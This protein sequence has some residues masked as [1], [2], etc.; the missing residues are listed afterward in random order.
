MVPSTQNETIQAAGYP[1]GGGGYGPPPDGGGYGP[2]PGGGGYGP[3]PGGGGYGPPPGGG[4]YGPPP[5]GG[6]YG[7]PPG[8][9]GPADPVGPTQAATGYGGPIQATSMGGGGAPPK[10]KGGAGLI[11]GLVVVLLVL[12]GG[13]AAAW[14]WLRST[15]PELAKYVPKD[16]EVYVEVPS[17]TKALVSFVDMDPIDKAALDPDKRSGEMY[18][19]FA[20]AFDLKEEDAKAFFTDM[21]GV[22]F[23]GRDLDDEAHGAM[24]IGFGSSGAVEKFLKSERL[25]KDEKVGSGMAYH[26]E[27][28]DEEDTEDMKWSER[29]F[30]ELSHEG[31]KSVFVWFADQKLLVIG[32]TDYVEDISKVMGGSKES[33]KS[34]N[35]AFKSAKWPSGS[36]MIAWVDS[37]VVDDDDIKK[38]FMDG[39]G[40]FLGS[41]RFVDAGMVTT[42]SGELKG[43]KLPDDK[44]IEKAS[45]LELPN[46]VPADTLA[47]L[48]FSTKTGMTGEEAQKQIIKNLEEEDEDAAEKFEEAMEQSKEKLGLDIKTFYDLLGD[49]AI[50]AVTVDDDLDFEMIEKKDKEALEHVG[51][52]FALQIKDEAKAKK[53][54]K[55]AQE[56]L[57]ELGKMMKAEISDKDGG[58]M[59]EPEDDSVPVIGSL[60]FQGKYLVL[61]IGEKKRHNAMVDAINGKGKTLGDDKAHQK[62]LKAFDGKPHMLF[63]MDSGRINKSMLDDA[64]GL[65]DMMKEQGIPLKAFRLTGDDR[66]TTAMAVRLEA[67][68]GVWSY[69]VE[70]LN[71]PA[72]APAGMLANMKKMAGGGGGSDDDSPSAGG[73]SGSGGGSGGKIGIAECDEYV[74][75]VENCKNKMVRDAMKDSLPKMIDTWKQ[76][77]AHAA[78]RGP[79]AD[80]CKQAIK[81][82]E[83][84]CR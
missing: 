84:Q 51:V 23:A 67:N 71:L 20:K 72:L 26:I 13:A 77:A 7:P 58:F 32:D 29:A 48:A 79:L 70:G 37:K 44:S 16:A 21:T 73:G 52:V 83:A 38:D 65:E 1:P 11:I 24:L 10:K 82:I 30:S 80:G 41:M 27:K 15:G 12:G 61:A 4:G 2:P 25:A 6:G 28:R 5:G 57:E 19:G 53:V 74:S 64:E 60:T 39:V 35:D 62:A 75:L 78:A 3:P 56:E 47:Y 42:L 34:G 8:G 76:G 81:G 54:V 43:K 68:K 55:K 50:L 45:T 40:P 59:V 36:T 63:W 14:M 17:F 9:G 49:E 66:M 33:L 22:A 46:K 18:K 69:Q 31:E